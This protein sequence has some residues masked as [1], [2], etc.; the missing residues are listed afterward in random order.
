M[1]TLHANAF[2]LFVCSALVAT[3]SH[4]AEEDPALLLQNQLRT[5]LST[6][7]HGMAEAIRGIGKRAVPT[8]ADQYVVWSEQTGT[9]YKIK[10]ITKKSEPDMPFPEY[11]K[12]SKGGT[13]LPGYTVLG[14]TN[15]AEI[16]S[17]FGKP[18]SQRSEALSYHLPGY[19]GDDTAIFTFRNGKLA[20]VEWYWFID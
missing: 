15:Q 12:L 3:S 7:G 20:T 8:K 14:K 13:V 2:L 18:N 16:I 11:M 6:F 10:W 17:Q 9:N 4:A 1:N 5:D 19:Q